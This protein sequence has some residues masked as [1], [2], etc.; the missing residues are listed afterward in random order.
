MSAKVHLLG[1]ATEATSALLSKHPAKTAGAGGLSGGLSLRGFPVPGQ[2]VGD[3]FV[4]VIGD[5]GEDIGEPGFGVDVVQRA[6]FDQRVDRGGAA[7]A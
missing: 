2:Q 1:M 6:G 3:L 4:G 5:A 7:A